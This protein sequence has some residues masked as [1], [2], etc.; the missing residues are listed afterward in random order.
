MDIT[1]DGEKSCVRENDLSGLRE[2]SIPGFRKSRQC[3]AFYDHV[4]ASRAYQGMPSLGWADRQ[5]HRLP[6]DYPRSRGQ[7]Q[8]KLGT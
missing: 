4:Q 7:V 6:N 3:A 8:S 1:A 5:Y 2:T